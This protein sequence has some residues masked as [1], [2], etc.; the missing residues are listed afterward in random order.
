MSNMRVLAGFRVSPDAVL[1]A[2]ALITELCP[3]RIKIDFS[4]SFYPGVSIDSPHRRLSVHPTLQSKGHDKK[5]RFII[6]SLVVT[7]H[8]YLWPFIIAA[9]LQ[10]RT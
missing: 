6:C 5:C 9:V 3:E 1:W 4:Q 7:R 10:N 8:L 2:F